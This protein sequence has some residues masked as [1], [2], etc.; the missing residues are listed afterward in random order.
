MSH[1]DPHEKEGT[2]IYKLS[3]KS[4]LKSNLLHIKVKAQ[5]K[6]NHRGVSKKGR[7]LP[8]LSC[9]VTGFAFLSQRHLINV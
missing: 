9:G 4:P 6:N 5:Y 3:F 7:Q 2:N 1:V 8:H